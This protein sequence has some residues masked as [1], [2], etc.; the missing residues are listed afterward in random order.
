MAFAEYGGNGDAGRCGRRSA[1]AGQ[2]DDQ[3]ARGQKPISGVDRSYMDLSVSPCKDFYAYANGAFEKVPIPGEYAGL[4]REPGNR[5]TQLRHPQGNPRDIQPGPAGPRGAW[6]SAWA[7]STPPA[8]TRP[9]SSGEGLRP[10]T[11]WLGRIRAI[12][13]LNELVATIAQLQAAGAERG[14]QLRRRG[15]RQGQ[16]AMIAGFSQGGLGLPERDYYFR[17]GKNAEEIRAAYVT[18]IARTLE[19]AGDTPRRP[20][21]PRLPSW[22]LKASWRRP[23]ERSSICATPR[24]TTTSSRGLR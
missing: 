6:S 15:R 22:P 17:E 16:H 5:R 14:L 7:T 3:A 12:A 9:P 2:H 23:R 24:R 10:L 4:R 8:W 19:L 1:G 11:P 13:S 21:P 18:H 20:R